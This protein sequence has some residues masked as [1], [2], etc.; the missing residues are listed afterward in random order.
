MLLNWD[1]SRQR[2]TSRGNTVV[3][4]F[5]TP[6]NT[7]IPAIWLSARMATALFQGEKYEAN[8]LMN[9]GIAGDAIE[10]FEL[11]PGK[12]VSFAVAVKTD[13][14]QTQNVVATWEGSDPVLKNEYVALGA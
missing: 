3:E 5:Q 13:K 14:I 11:S 1:R 10:S 12:S 2:A 4:K 9:R 7:S 6:A 8:A